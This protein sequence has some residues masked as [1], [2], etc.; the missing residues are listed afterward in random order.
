MKGTR[1]NVVIGFMKCSS[2][3]AGKQPNKQPLP[4]KSKSDPAGQA[5]T[6]D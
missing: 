6:Y 3:R 4:Q 1:E 2:A 5:K